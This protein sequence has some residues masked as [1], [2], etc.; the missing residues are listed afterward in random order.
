[1]LPLVL[2]WQVVMVLG[3]IGGDFFKLC[4]FLLNMFRSDG[5]DGNTVFVLGCILAILL[6]SIVGVQMAKNNKDFL[7][8]K[9]RILISIGY[10]KTNKDT[11]ESLINGQKKVDAL[12]LS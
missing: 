11:G 5:S 6:D 10:C 9:Q 8:W 1:M 3:W 4:Y 12:H 2:I 7:L